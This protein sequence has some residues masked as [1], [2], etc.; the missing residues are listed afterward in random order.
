MYTRYTCLHTCVHLHIYIYTYIYLLALL[1][2]RQHA[3]RARWR[4]KLVHLAF[5]KATACRLPLNNRKAVD[6]DSPSP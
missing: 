1:D 2:T 5:S 6:R 4:L 3:F